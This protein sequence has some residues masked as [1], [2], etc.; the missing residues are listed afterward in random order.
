MAL[1]KLERRNY[2]GKWPMSIKYQ[3]VHSF[4][5]GLILLCQSILETIRITHL[6]APAH[7]TIPLTNFGVTWPLIPWSADQEAPGTSVDS[8]FKGL[9]SIKVVIWN[10]CCIK[11][12]FNGLVFFCF[13]FIFKKLT[14]KFI[15]CCHIRFQEM[16]Y[17]LFFV[18]WVFCC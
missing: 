2:G 7:F 5:E 6:H 18:I 13:L 11:C 1:H 14:L 12:I 4:K 9:Y 3:N 10:I 8:I 16:Q 17:M 15:T